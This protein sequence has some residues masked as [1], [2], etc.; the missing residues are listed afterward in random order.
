M[1]Q[2]ENGC[3][4]KISELHRIVLTRNFWNS[5]LQEDFTMSQG[6]AK[7]A[8]VKFADVKRQLETDA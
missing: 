3:G 6:L 4:L 1:L 8:G 5:L 7:L 2:T